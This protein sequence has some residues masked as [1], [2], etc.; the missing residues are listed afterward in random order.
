MASKLLRSI[1]FSTPVRNVGCLRYFNPAKS[2]LDFDPS[3]RDFRRVKAAVSRQ[4]AALSFYDLST[5]VA[6][7]DRQ[8]I[9]DDFMEIESRI[10]ESAALDLL[11]AYLVENH[12]CN[13]LVRI[14]YDPT[15]PIPGLLRLLA[16]QL[17]NAFE[18]LKSRAREA[19]K[20]LHRS[21]RFSVITPAIQLPQRS[22]NAPNTAPAL[23]LAAA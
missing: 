18:I 17:L 7:D 12:L 3:K 5:L 11:R 23:S 9:Y 6:P 16:T 8:A 20:R 4:I 1:R 19:L 21:F 10:G 13:E 22:P 2:I 14:A 15:K